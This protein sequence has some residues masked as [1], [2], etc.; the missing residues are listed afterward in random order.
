MIFKGRVR[1]SFGVEPDQVVGT[2]REHC[3]RLRESGP[4]KR[5]LSLGRSSTRAFVWVTS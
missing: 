3:T 5:R 2:L 4:E 1:A